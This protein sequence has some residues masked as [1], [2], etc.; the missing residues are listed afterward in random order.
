MRFIILIISALI[1]LT[2]NAWWAVGHM[3]VAEVAKQDLIERFPEVYERAE[4]ISLM[5]KGLTNNLSDTF[6]ESAVWMDDIKLAPWDSFFSWHFINK[7]Y[8][9]TGLSTPPIETY[10]SV[11][12]VN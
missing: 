6:I 12:A 9:P 4:N 7:P 8:N 10:N 3:S 11:Y 1:V 5:V 2:A